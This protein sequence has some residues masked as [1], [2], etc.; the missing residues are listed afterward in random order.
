M[1]ILK[2]EVVPKNS[3]AA[4]EVKQGQRLR[5]AGK[6]RRFRALY[7][8]VIGL[9]DHWRENVRKSRPFAE[10]GISSFY[11]RFPPYP[12]FMATMNFIYSTATFIGL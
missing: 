2:S 10:G 12:F 3:G 11:R 6:H 8:E 1:A 5:I 7:P 9:L 4:V